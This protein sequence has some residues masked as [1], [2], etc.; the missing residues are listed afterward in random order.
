MQR[1]IS[2]HK[3]VGIKLSILTVLCLRVVSYKFDDI[4]IWNVYCFARRCLKS[5]KYSSWQSHEVSSIRCVRYFIFVW[6]FISSVQSGCF[7]CTNQT[8]NKDCCC[9]RCLFFHTL[10]RFF[11]LVFLVFVLFRF[12]FNFFYWTFFSVCVMIA[13]QLARAINKVN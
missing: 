12:Y 2:S 4:F 7:V 13:R 8:T 9:Y 3:N 6:W 1:T 10:R 11:Q 5:S